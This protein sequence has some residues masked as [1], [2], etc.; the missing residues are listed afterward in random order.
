M[1]G[2]HGRGFLR[3]RT[4]LML[5]LTSFAFV[6]L[7]AFQQLN[8]QHDRRL[9]IVPTSMLMALMEVTL[10]VG[11]VKSDSIYS[12]I[13]IGAGASLGCLVAMEVHRRLRC[14]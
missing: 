9:W 10:I 12:A 7:K 14:H 6:S 5:F 13:P 1:R 2:W 3:A 4:M 8:V 11:I